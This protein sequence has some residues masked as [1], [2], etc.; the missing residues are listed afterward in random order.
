[1]HLRNLNSIITGYIMIIIQ[2]SFKDK[3]LAAYMDSYRKRTRISES[4]LW[5][6]RAG[7]VAPPLPYL[8]IPAVSARD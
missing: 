2:I 3:P 6:A 4:G 8:W 1:M 7:T 5:A